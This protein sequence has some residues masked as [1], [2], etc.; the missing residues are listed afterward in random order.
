MQ[1]NTLKDLFQQLACKKAKKE[2]ENKKQKMLHPSNNL[3]V[4]IWENAH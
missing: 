4:E 2:E 3:V 1:T